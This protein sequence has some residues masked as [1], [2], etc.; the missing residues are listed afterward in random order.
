MSRSFDRL[1]VRQQAG[2]ATAK[3]CAAAISRAG[4]R[5]AGFSALRFNAVAGGDGFSVVP[6][7]AH[8]GTLQN[9]AIVNRP[10]S[11]YQP[12]SLQLANTRLNE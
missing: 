4:A 9:V 3:T 1:Q 7:R 5:F 6:D 11:T 8:H 12:E 2:Q 10:P